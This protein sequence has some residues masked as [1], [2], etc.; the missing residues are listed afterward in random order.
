MPLVCSQ[1][2]IKWKEVKA[3]GISFAMTKATEGLTCV[4]LMIS[5]L[6]GFT[7]IYKSQLMGLV[8]SS[9]YQIH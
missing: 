9:S 7:M 6:H 3:S 8:S 1:G 5:T 4:P 2:D